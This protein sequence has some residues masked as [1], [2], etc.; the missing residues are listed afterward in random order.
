MNIAVI[1]S[2]ENNHQEAIKYYEKSIDIYK[3][4]NEAKNSNSLGIAL[5]NIGYFIF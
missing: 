2:N 5:R 4:N 3:A 1:Y